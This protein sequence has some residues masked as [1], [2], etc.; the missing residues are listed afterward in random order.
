MLGPGRQLRGTVAQPAAL[1]EAFDVLG[2]EDI[3]A[4][5][6]G[7]DVGKGIES[8][9]ESSRCRRSRCQVETRQGRSSSM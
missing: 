1:Q 2:N 8:M 7:P 6:E 9:T 3:A 5:H 4:P